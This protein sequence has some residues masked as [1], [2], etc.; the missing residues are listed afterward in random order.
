MTASSADGLMILELAPIRVTSGRAPVYELLIFRYDPAARLFHR[1]FG[2]DIIPQWNRTDSTESFH[3]Q[4]LKP[5]AY[6]INL[7]HIS[8]WA[9]CYNAGTVYFDVKPGAATYVG[10]F[11]P[12]QSAVTISRSVKAGELPEKTRLAKGLLYLVDGPRPDIRGPS[13]LPGWQDRIGQLLT[14]DYPGVTAPL[15]GAD[16][17]PASFELGNVLGAE[18]CGR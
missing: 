8:A 5:G 12:M 9:T 2:R 10:R 14:R 13:E 3:V 1:D 17:H 18:T 4:V 11:D 7:F 6:A 15:V 16:L